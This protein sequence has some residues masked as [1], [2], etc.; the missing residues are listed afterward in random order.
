MHCVLCIMYV[1]ETI[2]CVDKGY[3]YMD[4]VTGNT[5]IHNMC[6]HVALYALFLH[7]YRVLYIL[8]LLLYQNSCSYSLKVNSVILYNH[9]MCI[10]TL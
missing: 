2:A 4:W 6:I 5:C 10:P 9:M 1:H 3:I 8:L 7:S